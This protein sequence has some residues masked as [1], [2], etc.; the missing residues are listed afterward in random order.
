MIYHSQAGTCLRA[1][2]GTEERCLQT[3]GQYDIGTADWSPDGTTI[4]LT[5]EVALG[6]EPERLGTIETSWE[7]LRSVAWAEDSVAWF[8]GPPSGGGGAVFVAG[9]SGESRKVLAGEYSRLSFSA[10]G[11][12]LLADQP[13]IR[14]AD[15]TRVDWVPDGMLVSIGD[16]HPVL[17]SIDGT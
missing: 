11:H 14:A 1:V 10:D 13:D 15:R 12:F 7:N 4:A 16:G 6:G 3:G 2:D 5:D 9:L 17:L 8:S